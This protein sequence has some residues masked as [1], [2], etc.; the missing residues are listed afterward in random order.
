MAQEQVRSDPSGEWGAQGGVQQ[1]QL[2]LVLEMWLM[3]T[4]FT[5]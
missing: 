3:E 4:Q 1:G 5:R 2:V